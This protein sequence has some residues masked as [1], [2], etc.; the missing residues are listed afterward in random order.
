MDYEIFRCPSCHYGDL[1]NEDTAVKCPNCQIEFPIVKGAPVLINES[2]SLFKFDDYQNSSGSSD[3]SSS[4]KGR[5][6]IPSLSVNLSY[7]KIIAQM[8]ID[9]SEIE[10]ASVL[11][12]GAGMQK[13]EIIE[14]MTSHNTLKITATD[15]DISS[16][17]DIFCDGHDLPF[18]EG[19]FHAVITTAV[20]EHVADPGR[21]L[22]EIYRVTVPSGLVYSEFPFMQQVHEGAYDFFRV[23]LTGHRLL[24][25]NYVELSA[26]MVA[27]PATALA[28]ALENF[29]LSFVARKSL[30]VRRVTKL[31]SRYCFFWLK[32]FDYIL[33]KNSSN[34]DSASCT[35]FYGKKSDEP[36]SLEDIVKVYSGAKGFQHL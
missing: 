3:L 36:V 6:G 1:K 14:L 8:A 34:S 20:L 13:Q 28:W 27:G 11:V 4:L 5:F 7:K 25:K 10:N 29:T 2:N 32:Y 12:V 9:L 31:L 18:K 19:T 17:V 30:F 15:I 16:D 24:M 21:V 35:Y 22:S 26:G 33:A 23:T